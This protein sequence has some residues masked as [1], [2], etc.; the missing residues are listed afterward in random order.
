MCDCS[1]H[2]VNSRPAKVG[3]Q[4]VVMKF[5]KTITRGFAAAGEPNVAVL[6]R[7]IPGL[8]QGRQFVYPGFH[9]LVA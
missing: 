3:D 1:L 5:A 6:S 8:E 2:L 4:L 7:D 9:G